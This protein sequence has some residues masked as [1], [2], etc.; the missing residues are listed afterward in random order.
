MAILSKREENRRLFLKYLA[1]SPLLGMIDK[2]AMAAELQ[3][4]PADPYIWW[5][6]DPNYAVDKPEDALDLF[7]IVKRRDT[8]GDVRCF[9]PP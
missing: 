9:C 2:S 3:V 6:H 7:E 5:P 4:R 1:A 8:R